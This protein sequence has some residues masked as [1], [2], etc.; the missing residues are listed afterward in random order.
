GRVLIAPPETVGRFPLGVI[1]LH[2]LGPGE[3]HRI[4]PCWCSVPFRRRGDLK[5]TV[6]PDL[7][8]VRPALLADGVEHHHGP[9]GWLA[10]K[11]H[12]SH[13]RAN[14]GAIGLLAA[15]RQQEGQ[16]P[17][18]PKRLRLAAHGLY[19]SSPWAVSM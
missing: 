13:N 6:G 5:R 1:H 14:N 11:E 19:T 7:A 16:K 15:G 10:L 17:R 12:L 18:P 4:R 3:R 8:A 9:P 2:R